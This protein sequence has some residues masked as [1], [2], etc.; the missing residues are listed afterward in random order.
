MHSVL[1]PSVTARCLSLAKASSLQWRH[2]RSG[3]RAYQENHE[4]A[5]YAKEDADCCD[6]DRDPGIGGTSE[7]GRLLCISI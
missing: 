2:N 4:E 6:H 1:S 3:L 7:R 5:T